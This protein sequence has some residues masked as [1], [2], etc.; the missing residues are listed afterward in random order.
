MCKKDKQTFDFV[1]M[2]HDMLKL[3]EDEQFF[4]ALR[5]KNEGNP[6][7]R[8]LDGP[9]TAN[10]PMGVHHAWG[11]TL[12]DTYLRYKGMN[13][14][15]CHYRNGFDTQGLWVEVEVE[16]EL[17]FQSKA[18]IEAYGLENFTKKCIE[19][20]TT[21]S[22]ILTEQSKR[23]G[24]WMDWEHSYFTHKDG[25]IEGIWHFLRKCHDRGWI[26]QYYKPMPWCPRC[27]TSLSDHEMSGSYKQITHE[28]VFF[29]LP[30]QGEA[31]DMLVWTTTPWTLAA[32]VALAVNPAIDYAMVQLEGDLRPMVL[33]K[34]ALPV[35]KDCEKTVVKIIKG[36]ALLGK[37]YDT[38]FPHMQKQKDIHHRVVPWDEVDAQEGTGV[39]HIAPGCGAE[40]YELGKALGL[41]KVQPVDASGVF[42]E[43]FGSLTGKSVKDVNP[44]VFQQLEKEHK[45]FKVLDYEHSYPVCWRCKTEVIYRLVK[46]WYIKS[47]AIRPQLIEAAKKVTWEPEHMGKRMVDWLTNMG[48][49]NISRKRF[50]GLPLP[51]YVCEACGKLT[52]V[53]SKKELLDRQ[54]G[55]VHL[56][57]LHRPWIDNVQIRCPHCE[58]V[59]N[60]V[61]DV[62]DVWLDAGIVPFSTLGYFEDR[63]KWQHYFPAEWITEMREQVRLWF[64]SMLFMSVVLEER[65]PY[66][67]V[68]AYNMVVSEDG[69]KFSK[70]GHMIKF[71]EAA[72]KMGSD[73][74]RYLFASTHVT[75]EVRFGFNVGNEARRKLMSLYQVYKFFRMYADID[76]PDVGLQGLDK[77]TW[78]V[79]DQ[80]LLAKTSQF[81][82]ECTKAYEQYNTVGVIKSYEKFIDDLSN[83]Y[84]RVNRRRFWKASDDNSKKHAYICLYHALKTTVQLIAPIVP[85][86]SEYI[87]QHGIRKMEKAVPP[88]V[89]LSN[90]P[91][92]TEDDPQEDVLQEVAYARK[93]IALT[94]RLRN[95]KQIKVRQPLSTM[96]LLEDKKG[97]ALTE[98]MKK[99]I[100][101][102]TNVKTIV[103]IKDVDQLQE[104]Y[105]TLDFRKAG[106]VL[107]KE[108]PQVKEYLD[109]AEGQTMEHLV[110]AYTHDGAVMV[111][112]KAYESALFI[113][114]YRPLE[115]ILTVSEDQVIVGLSTAID[116][117]L[118]LEGY[119][120]DMVRHFQVL[121]K[122][123]GYGLEQRIHIA[124]TVE[125][126]EIEEVI[127]RYRDYLQQELL[128]DTINIKS[129][130]SMARKTVSIGDKQVMIMSQEA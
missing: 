124:V 66:E 128:A 78:D 113:K 119:M 76:Q 81:I 58:A 74:I 73:V 103:W 42:M 77:T 104:A 52:V 120:R 61:P 29:R 32:N 105:L 115:N 28:S 16:K 38:C 35:L 122:E 2:E 4:E 114:Q 71:D 57:E 9:I 54:H 92:V 95:E 46:E 13:G 93:V 37:T 102:E 48:D 99:V 116:E 101:D 24:Q 65:P 59:V 8:F 18:D 117:G 26:V 111:N 6:I 88:S 20:I 69:S 129:T 49:W 45:L 67:K 36:E 130:E 5:L 31:Y 62:G 118:K 41:D 21:Y 125:D 108:L 126:K 109:H 15:D 90:W 123:L 63:E 75:N 47:D 127:T 112:Q 10:N 12:K 3:W 106:A 110:H 23:L 34:E 1:T 33:A 79:L 19:R 100:L 64:Y 83:W 51:F 68:L 43:G 56:P 121:R 39:V 72:E 27:G 53:G 11:R 82:Q 87:W 22:G 17:G 96:Y 55:E 85:F 94:L 107:G 86:L 14:Y 40:D 7:F 89:H 30:V 60:R 97:K 91:K 50:Y 25:N 70:T 98:H 84:I 44:L 80:W